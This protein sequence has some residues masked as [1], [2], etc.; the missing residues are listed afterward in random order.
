M[1]VGSKGS[2]FDAYA[3]SVFGALTCCRSG[4]PRRTWRL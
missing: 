4:P 3:L 2:N 1:E